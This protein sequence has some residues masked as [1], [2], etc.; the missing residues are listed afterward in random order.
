MSIAHLTNTCPVC[1][2]EESLDAL[3]LRMVADETVR[4]LVAELLTK[5]LPLGDLVVRYLRLHTPPKQRL[6]LATVRKLLAELVPDVQRVAIERK[7]RVWAVS[8]DA[9]K[10]AFHAVFEAAER[11]KITLPLEGNA[12]LY[13]VV[14]RI[15]D[16]QEGEA[17]QQREQ[18][19][20]QRREQ[21]PARSLDDLIEAG[22]SPEAI[23]ARLERS[24]PEPDPDAAAKAAAIRERLKNER[25]AR[26]ARQQE[27]EQT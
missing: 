9:W 21:T 6:R 17:E 16:R 10:A 3:L 7:G 13:G 11:G 25:A 5:A 1:G 19:R 26:L 20:R 22:L 2:A 14:V 4:L 23:G 27:G 15:A 8:P 18:D 12:Y 24:E